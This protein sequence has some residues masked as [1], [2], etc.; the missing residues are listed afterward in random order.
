MIESRDQMGN[1]IR[2]PEH[3][4]RI[5]SLVP[6]LT[7]SLFDLGLD[8]EIVGVTEY[9]VLPKEKVSGRVKVGGTKQFRFGVID[10]LRPD[11]IF[12]NKEENYPEGIRRLRERYVVWMSDVVTVEDALIMIRTMGKLVDRSASAERLLNEMET[13]LDDLE[14]YSPL[15][16]AYLIWKDPYMAAGGDTFI[17]SMLRECG[18]INVFENKRKYPRITLDEVEAAQVILLSSEP[19]PFGAADLEALEKRCP[20]RHVCLVDGTMF[21]WYGSRVKYA[22][23]YFRNLRESLAKGPCRRP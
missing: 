3:P 19:Y 12:G 16:A 18:F 15:K 17:N 4:E 20:G 9:C 7:E 5:V 10:E 11:L 8:D 23:P 1:T 21:S 22:A 6:S 14:T 13:A 2:T